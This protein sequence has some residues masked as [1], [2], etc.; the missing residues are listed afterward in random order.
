MLKKETLGKKQHY[1]IVN[2]T[3]R[4]FLFNELKYNPEEPFYGGPI[5]PL[6]KPEFY[7]HL[8]ICSISDFD[9]KEDSEEILFSQPIDLFETAHHLECNSIH[10]IFKL[11][12][13]KILIR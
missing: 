5:G 1:I 6:V 10:D 12:R 8:L 7:P 4:G 3:E 9:N 13:D 2:K 11:N